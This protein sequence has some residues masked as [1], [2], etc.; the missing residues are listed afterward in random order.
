MRIAY[1]TAYDHENIREWSGL[2]YH[3]AKSLENQGVELTYIDKLKVK[4][5]NIHAVKKRLC[6]LLFNKI[7][8]EDRNKR[9]L[10][11]FAK[12][13]K[14]KLKNTDFDLI[15]CPSSIPITFL[16]SDKPIVIYT[17]ATFDL[18]NDFYPEFKKY[19]KQ[20]KRNG[21][22]M[23]KTALSNVSMA[24]YSSQWAAN[25][26]INHYGLSNNN[27]SVI[28]FG[29][30]FISKHT[31][32]SIK[33]II[34]KRNKNRLEIL[35][36]AAY[37]E[38]KGG[39]LV[40]EITRNLLALGIDVR[41]SIVGYSPD[42]DSKLQKN[43]KV[44]GFID[45]SSEKGGEIFEEIME[46]SHF[47]LLPS[48]A[49]CT[50]VVFSEANSFGIPC[51]STNVGGINEIILDGVNGKT[52]SLLTKSQEYADY[53]GSIYNNFDKYLELANSS[54]IHYSKNL[55]W[56]ISGKKLKRIMEQLSSKT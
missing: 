7:Y 39:P 24:V 33:E 22:K 15:F 44:Y 47:M 25:S 35:F 8:R 23:E 10:K 40:L 11:Y 53:I 17:D 4:N 29:A 26:A 21:E 27:V 19:C 30:N 5:Y 43:V 31:N 16:K 54:Y 28:P 1:L 6:K 36:L 45:K 51:I 20:T 13:I 12:Q 49:D 18:L 55:N 48:V 52:F 37:W 50:P 42:I 9:V 3:I 41:L 56:E 2:G 34:N 32:S 14:R 38:R 46:R